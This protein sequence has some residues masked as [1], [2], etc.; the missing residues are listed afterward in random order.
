MPR[1]RIPCEAWFSG[2]PSPLMPR[3]APRTASSPY[4][5]RTGVYQ[6]AGTEVDPENKHGLRDQALVSV[7]RDD[8]TVFDAKAVH[9]IIGKPVIDD[10]P[11]VPVTAD[12][13]R[14]LSRGTIMG[15]MRDGDYLAFD[16][17]VTNAE[18]IANIDGGIRTDT[19]T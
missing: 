9:N 2:T 19:R 15:A 3:A 14:Q 1:A 5:A 13:Q 17:L 11:K 12:N 6:H 16:L 4:A 10:H 7:L 18:A 8:N